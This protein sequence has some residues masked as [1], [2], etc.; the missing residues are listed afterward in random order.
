MAETSILYSNIHT[1]SHCVSEDLKGATNFSVLAYAWHGLRYP[2]AGKGSKRQTSRHAY[3]CNTTSIARRLQSHISSHV[4]HRRPVIDRYLGYHR[5][6]S[7]ARCPPHLRSLARAD[8]A[9][10]PGQAVC[11]HHLPHHYSSSAILLDLYTQAEV[12]CNPD[13]GQWDGLQAQTD[14]RVTLVT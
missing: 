14:E 10:R 9:A 4:N 1:Y 7:R 6:F 11:V 8:C 5:A 3:H 13:R 2:Q 12:H